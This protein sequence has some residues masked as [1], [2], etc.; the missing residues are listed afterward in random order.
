MLHVRPNILNGIEIRGVWRMLMTLHSKL[1]SDGN[2]DL[3]MNRS[4]V[5]HDN[6]FLYVPKCLFPELH[7]WSRQDLISINGGI[8]LLS[9]FQMKKHTWPHL[10]PSKCPPKHHSSPSFTLFV[11]NT[12]R[13]KLLICLA[14]Y[15]VLGTTFHPNFDTHLIS[16]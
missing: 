5:L 6:W 7:E 12:I 11:I 4:I 1:L 10:S 15:P 3:F 9:I 16:P 8:H 2:A 13:V 14:P